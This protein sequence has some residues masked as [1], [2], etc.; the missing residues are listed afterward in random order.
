MKAQEPL[1][2][3]WVDEGPR[4]LYA[5]P[6]AEGDRA[7]F[8]EQVTPT[9]RPLSA[10]DYAGSFMA[11]LR[12]FAK[13]SYILAEGGLYWCVEWQPGL[14]VIRVSPEGSLSW[15]AM[16]SPVP[17]FG[18]REPLPGDDDNYDEDAENPTYNLIFRAWDAQFDEEYREEDGFVPA[19]E[20][21]AAT[22]AA[23]MKTLNDIGAAA[24][25]KLKQL[26]PAELDQWTQRAF[27]RIAEMA[28]EGVRV[29]QGPAL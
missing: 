29:R 24:G 12:T 11:I 28:G 6:L 16:R 14:L 10:E 4:V 22:F 26:S 17:K 20:E 25:E 23:L 9:L 3:I 27:Q 13:C 19:D 1:Y 7:F 21:Q 15:T 18:G 2:M 8:L 5:G